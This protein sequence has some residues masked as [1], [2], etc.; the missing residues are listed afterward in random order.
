MFEFQL[1]INEANGLTRLPVHLIAERDEYTYR[2]YLALGQFH[3][4]LSE[5][6]D[7]STTPIGKYAYLRN[8]QSNNNWNEI[9]NKKYIS[10]I[11]TKKNTEELKWKVIIREW[12]IDY[13]FV[14]CREL[15]YTC[16][17]HR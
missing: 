11:V 17:N 15:Y 6:K 13:S 9:Q 4:I 1:A 5:I 14:N 2:S 3:I 10:K 12:S 7:V 8:K 16:E